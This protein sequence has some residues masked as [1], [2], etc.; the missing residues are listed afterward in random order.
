MKGNEWGHPWYIF[1]PHKH[2]E[3]F[4]KRLKIKKKFKKGNVFHLFFNQ[5]GIHFEG[6]VYSFQPPIKRREWYGHTGR[7]STL[8]FILLRYPQ[9]LKKHFINDYFKNIYKKNTI[10]KNVLNKNTVKH[11]LKVIHYIIHLII[12]LF[13]KCI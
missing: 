5:W 4:L 11:I 8:W 1:G 6:G 3:V 9:G 10:I 13:K 12:L 7:A 2:P